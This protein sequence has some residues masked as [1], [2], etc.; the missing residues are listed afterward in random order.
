MVK[1][2]MKSCSERDTCLSMERCPVYRAMKRVLDVYFSGNG[3]KAV[4][5][6]REIEYG[7][8]F[9]FHVYS[10]VGSETDRSDSREAFLTGVK[11][12]AEED[13]G[14][15]INAEWTGDIPGLFRDITNAR[16]RQVKMLDP[17]TEGLDRESG[18]EGPSKGQKTG[19]A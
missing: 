13:G 19:S 7:S 4:D 14:C 17:H 1:T 12:V 10:G 16:D 8:R 11:G 18:S 6:T 15:V 2:V 5:I 3:D 9:R